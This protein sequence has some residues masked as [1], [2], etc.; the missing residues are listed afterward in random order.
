MRRSSVKRVAIVLTITA[1]SLLFFARAFGN[2][3]PHPTTDSGV[4]Y[5]KPSM[6]SPEDDVDLRLVAGTVAS[7]RQIHTDSMDADIP[8]AAKP[9][10]TTLKHQLRDLIANR[11][12]FEKRRVSTQQLQAKAIVDLSNLGLIGNEEGCVIVDANYVDSG[13]DYGDIE[14]ITVTRPHYAFDVIAVTTTV[15][16]CCGEDTSLYLFKYEDEEWKLWL[17]DEKNDY[18][19]IDS[20]QGL[21]EFGLSWPDENKNY[22]VVT[23]SVNPWCTSNWQ[24]ITYRVL[25][26][27]T[28]PYEPRV[29][30]SR[31]KT[32]YLGA[33]DPPYRLE[34]DDSS[35]T[36]RFYGDKYGDSVSKGAEGDADDESIKELVQFR[37]KGD[38]VIEK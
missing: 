12:R 15:G 4:L 5:A 33:G 25:R 6:A 30:L 8:V 17:A 2:S 38:A 24:S 3:A 14:S 19:R 13:Y 27:G 34:V 10:L 29:L 22:F 26:P 21:F 23:A 36:L 35:F 18:D 11:L 20:A 31:K 16:I 37:L 7:L 32:I 9:L 28:E 1:S